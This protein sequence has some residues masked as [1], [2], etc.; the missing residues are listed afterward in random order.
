MFKL[1]V[2]GEEEKVV[3]I[4]ILGQGCDE[5]M[6]GFGVAIKMGGKRLMHDVL[7]YI[8]TKRYH[9]ATKEDLDNTVAIHPTSAEGECPNSEKMLEVTR[10]RYL[11]TRNN[12][13]EC[14]CMIY[15]QRSLGVKFKITIPCV[16]IDFQ[17]WVTQL[18]RIPSKA[19]RTT[20]AV[21]LH[22]RVCGAI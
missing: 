9:V 15:A 17:N 16:I 3:G 10:L 20:F 8:V 7:R 1:I 5:A 14:M 4:H 2:V 6:Q 22:Q 12:D 11:R 21:P 19:T 13:L 18:R